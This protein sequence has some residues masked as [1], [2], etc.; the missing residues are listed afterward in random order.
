MDADVVEHASQHD[1][2]GELPLITESARVSH[3]T[4]MDQ[5]RRPEVTDAI[6]GWLEDHGLLE[7]YGLIESEGFGYRRR[8]RRRRSPRD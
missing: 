1:A 7:R 5:D 2:I 4:K 6:V 3:V 8:R